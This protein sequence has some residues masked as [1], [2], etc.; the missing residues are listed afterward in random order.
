MVSDSEALK[1]PSSKVLGDW[2]EHWIALRLLER[3]WQVKFLGDAVP[4]YDM[5]AYRPDSCARTIQV[6]TI[7]RNAGAIDLGPRETF[8][9]DVLIFVANPMTQ[10][11]SAFLYPGDLVRA[12][13]TSDGMAGPFVIDRKAKK[14]T[15]KVH[16]WTRNN[17]KA[18]TYFPTNQNLEA[19]D[20][21]AVGRFI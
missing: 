2:G 1:P 14:A 17:T 8:S 4:S 9:A 10:S 11:A 6:K 21:V 19:W 15:G 18:V 5:I 7:G 16:V 3:G 20:I 13:T 12:A